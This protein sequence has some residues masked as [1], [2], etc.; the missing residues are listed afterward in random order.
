MRCWRTLLPVTLALAIVPCAASAQA[1][2]LDALVWSVPALRSLRNVV[3]G[4]S[5]LAP[6][7]VACRAASVGVQSN[8]AAKLA[9]RGDTILAIR[10]AGL[11]S[12]QWDAACLLRAIDTLPGLISRGSMSRME[13]VVG[14]VRSGRMSA[15]QRQ[16]FAKTLAG[17][18][19]V[20]PTTPIALNAEVRQ[21]YL[22]DFI[23]DRLAE[24][25]SMR[26]G[27]VLPDLSRPPVPLSL[28]TPPLNYPA[29][30]FGKQVVAT[31]RLGPD[32]VVEI[33]SMTPEISDATYRTA[34]LATFMRYRFRPAT[35]QQGRP[36]GGT[37]V[38]TFTF[39][40]GG[41][42]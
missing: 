38:Y 36:V 33:V 30:M 41:R 3:N 22:G 32:G 10:Y 27:R 19:P 16:A 20:M 28:I 15:E 21:D 5:V 24:D 18:I 13:E 6:A 35:D 42:P 25:E 40:R 26:R 23:R 4:D 9:E 34:L 2:T 37:F 39:N 1:V 29:S 7:L 31:F 8:V 14:S 11:P 12:T 17:A